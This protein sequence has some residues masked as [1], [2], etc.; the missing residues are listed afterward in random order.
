[1]KKLFCVLLFISFYVHALHE[2][3]MVVVVPSYNNAQWYKQNLDSI[4]LQTYNNYR[5]IYIDDCSLDGTGELVRAYINEHDLH[6]KVTLICNET[7]KGAMANHYKAVWMCQDHEVIVHLDGDDWFEN[8]GVLKRVNQE[9]QDPD[10][11]LTYGQFKR[12]PQ[13]K[14]GYCRKMPLDVVTHNTFREFTW[15]TSHL[16][17]F[18]AGLFKQIDKRDF[19]CNGNFLSVTCDI[20]MMMP[21][22]ERFVMS[23]VLSLQI[24][25][26]N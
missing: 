14:M 5:V 1:M 12:F 21:L 17:T 9:Y 24:S 13:G 22:L 10:C 11:W 18:Y 26:S 16:R 8:K 6:D 15:I 20:A 23:L 4:R 2:K 3:S 7:N 25:L 19:E